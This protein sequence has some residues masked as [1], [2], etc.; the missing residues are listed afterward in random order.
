MNPVVHSA[1]ACTSSRNRNRSA[2]LA[3]PHS[4]VET[5]CDD[6][7]PHLRRPSKGGP[8]GHKK[9]HT[10]LS[11]PRFITT[12]ML[13]VATICHAAFAAGMDADK[14]VKV[15]LN[16]GPAIV[17]QQNLVQSS[18]AARLLAVAER[19]LELGNQDIAFD[20]LQALFEAGDADHP[21]VNQNSGESSVYD[22]GLAM[23]R[24]ASLRT[25][26]AWSERMDVVAKVD[27]LR[28]GQDSNELLLTSR[29]YP[30]TES[31]LHANLL[32]IRNMISRQQSLTATA[33][34]KRLQER[35]NGITVNFP[36]RVLIEI[37]ALQVERYSQG[38]LSPQMVA[39]QLPATT[40]PASAITSWQPIWT[41]KEDV[42]NTPQL[43]GT[44]AG[45]SQS[46]ARTDLTSNSWQPTLRGNQLILRTPRRIVCLDLDNGTEQWSIPTDTITQDPYAALLRNESQPAQA[47]RLTEVLR[48]NDLGTLTLSTD[49]LFFVD[50]FR[51][52]ETENNPRDV[53][54]LQFNRNPQPVQSSKLKGDRLVAVRLTDPPT[55]AWTTG[56][57][58]AFRYQTTSGP[59]KVSGSITDAESNL[60]LD[61]HS[62]RL[63]QTADSK[64][65]SK[66]PFNGHSFLGPPLLF[67]QSLFVLTA[68][69]ENIW[70]NSLMKGTGR[71]SWRR[72]IAYQNSLENDPSRR[73][74]PKA[75][76][77]GA[78]VVGIHNETIL[79]LLNTGVVIGASLP[80]GRVKWAT[81]LKQ[82]S[83]SQPALPP[84]AR[85]LKG[86]SSTTSVPPIL[87][88]D[89]LIWAAAAS[90]NLTCLNA[91][92]GAIEWQISQ[93]SEAP[94]QA[95]RSK[96]LLPAGIVNDQLIMTGDRHV[97]AIHL[98][99]GSVNWTTGLNS[100]CGKAVLIDNTCWV[101]TLDGTVVPID[102]NSGDKGLPI[103][104]ANA[105]TG[106]LYHNENRI[107]ATTPIS[108]Q[109]F[110]LFQNPSPDNDATPPTP[111]TNATQ[112]QIAGVLNAV[113]KLETSSLLAEDFSGGVLRGLM[114][115]PEKQQQLLADHILNAAV[116][117]D[118]LK[119]ALELLSALPLTAKQSIR[120]QMLLEQ[121]PQINAPADLLQ[122]TNNWFVR[123][124]LAALAL[125]QPTPHEFASSNIEEIVRQPERLQ[126]LSIQRNELSFAALARDMGV[127]RP[128][129][130]ELALLMQASTQTTDSER[131][132]MLNNLQTMRT[133]W[134]KRTG[135]SE[136]GSTDS[137]DAA[138]FPGGKLKFE[139]EQEFH[140]T[141][142]S[143]M[144]Q[145]ISL[146]RQPITIATPSPWSGRRLFLRDRKL[147]SVNLT[148]GTVGRS[149]EL[150]AAPD[151]W[152]HDDTPLDP[153]TPSLLP[154]AGRSHAGV[155]SVVNQAEPKELWWKR[156]DRAPYD[157][158][159][160]KSGPVTTSG[161]IFASNH[162]I[163]CLHPLTGATQ[164]RRDFS[165]GS[166]Q[167]VFSRQ[168]G[169]AADADHLIA[170]G[171][172]YRSGT[173]F[174]MD[175]GRQLRS[176][177]YDVPAG[178]TP[179]ISGSRLLFPNQ[180]RLKLIELATGT[181]VL[182]DSSIRILPSSSSQL[183]TRTRAVIV[184]DKQEIA[185]LNLN[186]GRLEFTAKF[187]PEMLR[188]RSSGL[189]VFEVGDRLF[190]HFRQWDGRTREISASSVVG[191]RRLTPG[192]LF[193]INK[194]TGEQWSIQIP[195]SVLMEIA[196]DPAPLMMLWSRQSQRNG[197]PQAFDQRNY[198]S[199]VQEQNLLLRIIDQRTGR[200][201]LRSE[202]LGWANPLRCFHDSESQTIT[203]E[204]D[205]SE[206]QLRYTGE[207]S[208]PE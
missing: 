167:S 92:T 183:L 98:S 103:R 96:D 51:V 47:G 85:Y 120:Q 149:L 118:D 38:R 197:M 93:A 60:S 189:Q 184:T 154:I 113:Q 117:S 191:D 132:Q 21:V 196:G 181:D 94:G 130:A 88:K 161:I 202:D 153:L 48:R 121:Q 79:C 6:Q 169:F 204:T 32:L 102:V 140:L 108:I 68:D 138:D 64:E 42:W 86:T 100:P 182:K 106:S 126:E 56:A 36:A 83:D 74:Q 208:D 90:G 168:V 17:L 187:P 81:S 147:F 205:A 50:H 137:K 111:A 39:A 162:R 14:P 192:T 49:F 59:Q 77:I 143:P 91:S 69:A 97:R 128:A 76:D 61:A 125:G 22:M 63:P 43:I 45:L 8:P 99:D 165:T 114:N 206:I 71:L 2:R 16:H 198:S 18:N 159:P 19:Q 186:T 145:L 193:S 35:Y 170:M 78:S 158:S 87:H 9:R 28:S 166:T 144:T 24:S 54:N 52:F 62:L 188:Q 115:L 179:I 11:E 37:A 201:L 185:V 207:D 84:S 13:L 174:R 160:L 15:A 180:Q 20:A 27:L 131:S 150:S 134:I 33:A 41:W 7:R 190:I 173:V 112:Q 175:D 26:S 155:V 1:A 119:P 194:S 105:I 3:N 65:P 12:L 157:N 146:A 152:I 172:G 4:D 199:N 142:V 53:V 72:P 46:D 34:L 25:R 44:F 171:P 129:A 110:P 177:K 104:S 176:L 122:L 5:E 200:E 57:G 164:W 29:K 151:R 139:V 163:T 156:W 10:I 66:N 133:Q 95:D 135:K 30:F 101:P 73:F 124:D 31:G 70:L 109:A 89:R 116:T 195:S 75:E 203:I 23:L 82:Q 55:V 148:N 80:D 141:M 123:S 107:V 67:E 136:S 178:I 40:N 127:N 58:G